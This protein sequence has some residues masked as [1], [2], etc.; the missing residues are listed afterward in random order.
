MSEC[1]RERSEGSCHSAHEHAPRTLYSVGSAWAVR[2]MKQSFASAARLRG[3]RAH[4]SAASPSQ[5]S[6]G[7]TA[8]DRDVSRSRQHDRRH[9]RRL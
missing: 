7:S 5:S 2:T 1:L 8:T 6:V 9:D 3:E 4:L